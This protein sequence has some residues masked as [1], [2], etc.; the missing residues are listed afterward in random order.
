MNPKLKLTILALLA[1]CATASAVL[2]FPFTS[3]DDL[4]QHSPDIVIARCTATPNPQMIGD[5]MIG[6]EIEVITVLKGDTKPGPAKMVSQYWPHQGEQFLMFSTYQINEHYRAYNATETYRVIPMDRYFESSKLNDKPL[7]EQVRLILS[8]R[9]EAVRK[10]LE[11]ATEEKK[12]LEQSPS[13]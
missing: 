9:L 1:V 11:R 12:R 7:P 13:K 4:T 2:I 10:E 8:H 6:A 3:W 5:G